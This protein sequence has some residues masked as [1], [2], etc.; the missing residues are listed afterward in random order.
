M[1]IDAHAVLETPL[2]QELNKT[3]QENFGKR[4]RAYHEASSMPFEN[5]EDLF[6]LGFLTAT[7]KPEHGGFGSS[8]TSKNPAIYLQGIRTVARV[9]PG[10]AHCM[11]VQNHVA[12][13]IDEIGT[14]KQRQLFL[15]PMFK[16][17]SVSSFVGSEANRKHM[18]VLRTTAKKVDG[19]YIVNGNKNYATNGY[20]NGLA[21]I[22]CAI[23]DEPDF[24]KNHLMV[25]VQDGMKGLSINHNWYSP[26][27]MRACPSP[28][29]YLDNVFIDED[30]VLGA[31]GVYPRGRWQGRFHLGFTANYLGAIE[32]AY[33]WVVAGLKV[34]GKGKDL[35]TQL[36]IGEC[37]TQIFSA[38]T[39][40]ETAINAWSTGDIQQAE[41]LSMKAK[42]ICASVA[43]SVSH[44]LI[45][46]SGSTA[47]FDEYPLGRLIRDLNTH[48]L[49]VGHDRTAQIIGASVLGETFDSTL[50]R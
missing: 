3:V 14:E 12:W 15:D 21:I 18:Y 24:N 26:T 9:S 50:Q 31:P 7:V 35:L 39:A 33:Q 11:Q 47:L 17:M 48:I 43:L 38:Q 22:F 44:E 25:I 10:T 28:E 45:M 27:G 4:E 6:K 5:L 41:L 32:G 36:R 37:E 2:L 30:H 34:R 23:E 49:H 29:I 46:L 19:G 1:N 16:K 40:F 8:T 13:A 20:E 42:S